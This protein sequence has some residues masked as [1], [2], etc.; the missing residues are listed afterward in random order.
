MKVISWTHTIVATFRGY[1]GVHYQLECENP[2]TCEEVYIEGTWDSPLACH[3]EA[4]DCECRIG[5]HDFCV[6]YDGYVPEIGPLC[7]CEPVKGC[8]VQDW[9]ANVGEE[10]LGVWDGPTVRVKVRTD[11]SVPDCPTLVRAMPEE[12]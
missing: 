1:D 6:E 2:D 9:F 4:P 3:C 12:K 5:E 8:G 10:M 11:W 7:R